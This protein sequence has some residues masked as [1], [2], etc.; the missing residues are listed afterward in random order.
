MRPL[1]DY[2]SQR[3]K[4]ILIMIAGVL[5]LLQSLGWFERIVP[6]IMILFSVGLISYGLFMTGYHKLIIKGD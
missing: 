5:L 4:G 3:Q 6:T 1:L 2:L